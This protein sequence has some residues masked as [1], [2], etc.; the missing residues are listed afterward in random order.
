MESRKNKPPYL[1]LSATISISMIV[2][3]DEGFEPR[4]AVLERIAKDVLPHVQGCVLHCLRAVCVIPLCERG[5][6][7]IVVGPCFPSPP[8]F[9][10]S[11]RGARRSSRRNSG[12]VATRRNEGWEAEGRANVGIGAAGP[13]EAALS[14]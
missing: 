6:H 9:F 8:L 13:R 12:P 11:P 3:G 5:L 7:A 14:R 2:L 4:Y 10:Y 1:R